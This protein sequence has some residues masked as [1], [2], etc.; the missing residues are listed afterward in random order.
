MLQFKKAK[1]YLK[2]ANPTSHA[3]TIKANTSLGSVSFEL[4]R[5]LS[6]SANTIA[7]IHQD[8]Y[9]SCAMCDLNISASPYYATNGVR[10]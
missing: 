6:Q 7:H 5:D 3:I 4:I 1:S 9:S 10:R 8:M 2:I